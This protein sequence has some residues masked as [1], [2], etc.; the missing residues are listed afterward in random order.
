MDQIER[1]RQFINMAKIYRL[2]TAVI[3]MVFL[4][5][6]TSLTARDTIVDPVDAIRDL[7]KGYLLVRLPAFQNKIDT[8]NALIERCQD[9]TSKKKFIALRDETLEERNQMKAEYLSAFQK[10]YKFSKAAYFFNSDHRTP[11]R[12]EY[13]N[14]NGD[15]IAY[16]EIRS[17]PVYYLVFSRTDE[18]KIDALVILD[19]HMEPIPYPFPNNFSRGGINFLFAKLGGGTFPEWRIKKMNARLYKFWHAVN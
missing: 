19:E 6:G 18:S 10:N 2:H 14:M 15:P 17:G 9:E 8:L 13:F 12:I 4:F 1:L 16:E 5:L 11:S 7:K 3:L